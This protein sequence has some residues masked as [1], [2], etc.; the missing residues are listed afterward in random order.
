[1]RV[2]AT[3]LP[4]LL[5]HR[6]A[7]PS[8]PRDAPGACVYPNRTLYNVESPDCY[9]RRFTPDGKYLIGFGRNMSGLHVFRVLSPSASV[10]QLVDAGN[11][12]NK[13]E[14]WH[15]FSLAWSR[16]YTGFGEA[17]HRDLCLVTPNMRHLIIVRLRR[18]D[19]APTTDRQQQRQQQPTSQL[20]S[21]LSCIKAMED[22]TILVVALSN[23][24][25]VDKREYPSDIIYLSGHNGI[26]MYDDKLCFLSLKNQCLRILR[27]NSNGT[28]ADEREIGWHTQP[29]DAYYDDSLCTREEQLLASMRETALKRK[30]ELATGWG[31]GGCL[32]EADLPLAIKRQRAS[33]ADAATMQHPTHTPP[34]DGIRITN[35]HDGPVYL[36]PEALDLGPAEPRGSGLQ[37]HIPA[38]SM[39]PVPQSPPIDSTHAHDVYCPEMPTNSFMSSATNVCF[40]SGSTGERLPF[41]FPFSSQ[42]QEAL[43]S[44]NEAE[45]ALAPMQSS[46]FSG[47]ARINSLAESLNP[48]LAM[49]S[50]RTAA[51]MPLQALQ[52]LPPHYRL[53]LTRAMQPSGRLESLADSDIPLIEPS[54]TSAP[55][56][57]L[58]QRLLGALFMRAKNRN[59][60]GLSLKYFY[61]TF[62]QYEGL[63]LWR[64][65]FVT[66]NRLL[67]RFV[68]LQVATSR[69][70]VPRSSVISSSTMANSFTVLAEYDIAEARFARI[71]DTA[72]KD[73]YR[74]VESRLDVYRAP[75][76]SSSRLSGA[77]NSHAPSLSNDVHLRDSFEFTQSAIRTARSGGPVQASRK[78]SALLPFAPQCTQESPILSPSRFKCNLRVRQ[79]IERFRPASMSPIRFYDRSTGRIKFVLSP[80]PY[81]S[82]PPLSEDDPA[83]L[84]PLEL[85]GS[86]D[87]VRGVLPS[88][89][90]LLPSGSTEDM[91]IAADSNNGSSSSTSNNTSNNSGGGGSGKA[92]IM[93]LLHPF[94]PLVLST[95]SDHGPN[96]LP[97]SNIHFWRG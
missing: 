31:F 78:A 53:M 63:V 81:H 91:S 2:E 87:A 28:L 66:R 3:S 54:L 20:P 40:S 56:S 37:Q 96:S 10:Q 32:D 44:E 9:F 82:S 26:S 46:L 13:S 25:I 33:H 50:D 70:H 14:F 4:A 84:C 47:G 48:L 23:G 74:E 79:M 39:Q 69:S 24:D 80:A 67:L 59:D 43:A 51:F 38:S 60:A 52:R 85:V 75:M 49:T 62:R 30:R 16:S 7:V 76:S 83:A 18:A 15:F 1:M 34:A 12:A 61:R 6:S 94:L 42:G 8:A 68:P 95:R 88:G 86:S 55:Y 57:G 27:I 36:T 64:A 72:E 22:I 93:Y 35:T 21:A 92:G 73:L 58:K 90:I 97:T 45:D 41:I 5:R 89:A 71:W 77:A 19:L 11:V 65:Q 17:L 29:D